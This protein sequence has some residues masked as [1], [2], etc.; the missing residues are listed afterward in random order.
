MFMILTDVEAAYVDFRGPNK[1]ALPKLTVAEAQALFD[2]GEFAKGSMGPK[3]QAA[4]KF[5]KSTGRTAI[6]TALDKVLDAL[7]G[8]TGTHVCP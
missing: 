2:K 5:A 7:D 6:I 4:I 3:V 8:K 1:R